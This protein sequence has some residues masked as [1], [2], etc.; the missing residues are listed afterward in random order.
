MKKIIIMLVMIS[1]LIV[2]SDKA[3]AFTAQEIVTKANEAS[4]YQAS[5]GKANVHMTITDSLGRIRE[6]DMRILRKDV[7][8]ENQKYYVYFNEPSDIK[9]MSYLVWKK[10]GADDDRWLYLPALD[11]VR[12]VASN[13]KRSSFV[14][15][16]F[17]YEDISGR[18]TEED[19]HVL[20]EEE[21]EMYK[22]KSVP[23]NPNSVEF[24]YFIIWIDKTNF[25]PRRAELYD[26]ND[27]L[28]KVLESL[29]IKEVQGFPTVVKMR[30]SDLNSG[31][32]TVSEFTDVEYDLGIEEKVFTERFL[33]KPPRKHIG[34]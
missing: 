22:I 15:S 31:G 5:D 25:M 12:R 14:G 16:N 21:N 24:S 27:K 6:R 8:G 26:K 19:E 34:G 28:Y 13:D 30:A 17:A 20:L 10:V 3:N 9:G 2:Y 23:K 18:G 33:R 4:Y 7:D 1:L 11:L 32:N 29:E